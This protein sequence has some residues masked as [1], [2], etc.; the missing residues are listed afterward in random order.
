MTQAADAA[1]HSRVLALAGRLERCP[2]RVR[3]W[4]RHDPI[5]AF[6]GR[7]AAQMVGQGEGERVLAFLSAI[8]EAD[9]R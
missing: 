5:R 7:T 8:V 3:E 6:G 2:E 9:G 4:Y 1:L